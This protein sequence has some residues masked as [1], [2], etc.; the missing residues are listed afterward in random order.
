[1]TAM[2]PQ[3]NVM[4]NDAIMTPPTAAQ[5][6]APPEQAWI[7]SDLECRTG[8]LE[9]FQNIS[10]QPPQLPHSGDEIKRARAEK[11]LN[12]ALRRMETEQKARLLA[13]ARRRIDFL[14]SVKDDEM[15]GFP[16]IREDIFR[17]QKACQ[18]LLTMEREQKGGVAGERTGIAWAG[19]CR[20][21]A[22]NPR[23]PKDLRTTK[24]EQLNP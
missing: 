9:Q 17:E 4:A 22:A 12:A 3:S 7:S 20:Q 6:T 1:M 15:P 11:R 16:S 24:E 8:V 10:D 18:E 19:V 21:L 2:N 5:A 23:K 14:G 13:E